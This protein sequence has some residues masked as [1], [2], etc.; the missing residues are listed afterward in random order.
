MADPSRSGTP[1]VETAEVAVRFADVLHRAGVPVTP[2]RAGRFASALRL[3]PPD[4]RDRLYWTARVTLLSDP[5]QLPCF[6]RVFAAVFEG[7]LDPA[8]SRGDTAGPP[9]VRARAVSRPARPE[10]RLTTAPTGGESAGPRPAGAESDISAEHER[11]AVLAAASPEERLRDIAFAAIGPEDVAALSQLIRRIALRTPTRRS[12]RTRPSYRGGERLDLRRTLRRA[13]RSGGDP[14]RLVLRRR[15]I[16]PRRLI[17]LCDVSG[18]MESYTQA[19][20]LLLQGAVVG[21]RA[22]AFVFATRLTR[23]TPALKGRDLDT[24]LE[25]AAAAAPDWAGGTRLGENLRRFIDDF[26]RRSMARGA[27]VLILS[28]GWD[29]ED[30]LLV[31]EQMARLRRL[32]YR[33]VWV[34]PRKAAPGYAPLVGGMAAAL[35][36]CDALVSGHSLA[37]L[38]EVV[39]VVGAGRGET[40]RRGGI[41]RCSSTMRSR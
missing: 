9:P 12:R 35:P 34:N 20:L 38:T 31:A 36:Y 27:V 40:V 37:A 3:L 29:Q 4:T 30:P 17:L 8:D 15:R 22:E 19:F 26:G 13:Q 32:A 39:D 14:A 25:D 7:T 5:G 23:L 11:P 33:I 1:A 2:Q 16:R 24:A 28:D 6:D 18:S 21:V 41:G 10:L